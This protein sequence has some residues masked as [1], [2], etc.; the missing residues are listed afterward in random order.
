MNIYY[1]DFDDILNPL[2]GAGQAT[3]TYEAG[4]ELVKQGHTV[5]V[6]CSKYP[7]Y[8]DRIQDGIS[9]KHIGLGTKNIQLNNLFYFFALPFSVK[10]L[11]RSKADIIIECFT[12]P[13][14]TLFS[15]L[16]TDVPI[17][18]LP[19]MFNAKQ[20][21]KKYHLPFDKIEKLGV[22]LYRYMMPYS[23]IDQAK[24]HSMNKN[25]KTRIVPQGVNTEYFKIN[26]T[27]PKHILFLSR[28]DI[29]QKGID[30]LLHAFSKVQKRIKY[31]LILAGHGPDEQKIQKMIVDLHLEKCVSIVGSAYGEK[32]KKLIEE[33]AFVVFP[34]RHDEMSLWALEALAS[35][36]PIVGFDLPECTWAPKSAYFTAPA[37]DIRAYG[38][39]IVKLSEKKSLAHLRKNA[40]DFARQYTWE[41]VA[42]EFIAFFHEI[43]K[44]EQK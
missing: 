18:V 26:V 7:G 44:D 41:N 29:D 28:F 14:S 20:F 3:A 35:G 6:L 30:L 33:S 40:K 16:F 2:L 25:I 37:F 17:V 8:K 11:D 9:Y 43:L 32:K 19:S 42:K 1:L 39:L 5:S 10:K 38:D 15:P 34:S 22:K 12:A 4:K 23:N 27:K 24:I 31:P 13:I 36:Q 21:A